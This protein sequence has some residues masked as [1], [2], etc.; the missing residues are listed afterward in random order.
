MSAP[1]EVSIIVPVRQAARTIRNT[2]AGLAAQ[3]R[4]CNA[5]IIA[6]VSKSD[7]TC[8]VLEQPGLPNV[9]VL[10]RPP[11][12]GVPQL[13]RDGVMAARA[14][15]LV[16]T[17]DHC[18]FPEGWLKNLLREARS[19]GGIVGGP[20]SNGRRTFAGWAQYFTRY[21]SFM[22][23]FSSGLTGMLP[24]NNA[25]Y[26]RADIE[27]QLGLM[28]EGFWEAEF[29]HALQA[30]GHRFWMAPD[31][32]VEQHQ[33]R[34]AFAYMPLRYRHGRCY[35]WRRSRDMQALQRWSLLARVPLVPL[36]L[37]V[38]A[39]R[40]VLKKPRYLGMF[41]LT[42]PLLLGYFAAW[43]AGEAAGYCSGPG[44]VWWDTD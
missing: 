10:V 21:A 19:R 22:P 42:T 13:R 43:G 34:G 4:D 39:A 36:L 20:V 2:L 11:G 35:G 30:G 37:Y 12:L 41:L 14:P 6:V 3:S 27:P 29:N 9:R 23:P 15:Y 32:A 40:N 33:E 16:I 5:E 1:P 44:A 38:R 26:S 28:E 8:E 25:I 31:A 17:E 18:T 24:G 7:G